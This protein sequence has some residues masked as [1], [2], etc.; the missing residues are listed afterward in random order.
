M[1]Q[2]EDGSTFETTIIGA[3]VFK[4][5]LQLYQKIVEQ[6]Q[7]EGKLI[8]KVSDKPVRKLYIV[9]ESGQLAG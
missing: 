2:Q 3:L 9:D 7:R 8:F 6:I 5:N 4:G 1:Q